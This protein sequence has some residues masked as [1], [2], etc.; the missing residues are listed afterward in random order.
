MPLATVTFFTPSVKHGG[1]FK[2]LKLAAANYF[3]I[4]G[5]YMLGAVEFVFSKN[6][7]RDKMTLL[8]PLVAFQKVSTSS[9]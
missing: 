3:F 5:V 6:W 8:Q 1:R 7:S 2:Q 4:N 9:H